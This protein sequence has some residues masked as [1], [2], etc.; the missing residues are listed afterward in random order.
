MNYR[1]FLNAALLLVGST[2]FVMGEE[3]TNR[4]FEDF[5]T[6]F[7]S[8]KE[9]KEKVFASE[10]LSHTAAGKEFFISRV[11][12]ISFG[13][14]RERIT[15]C[16]N[17]VKL[18]RVTCVW[19]VRLHEVGAVKIDFDKQTSLLSVT[20]ISNTPLKGKVVASVVL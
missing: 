1:F 16:H 9:L 20:A 8:K 13:S 6:H 18:G 12:L 4:F 5:P 14:S 2:L 7:S 15:C 17:D 3:Q 10:W 11:P 19:D